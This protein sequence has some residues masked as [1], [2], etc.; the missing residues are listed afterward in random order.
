ML[1]DSST[2][3]ARRVF[4]YCLERYRGFF[5]VFHDRFLILEGDEDDLIFLYSSSVHKTE[6]AAIN[7]GAGYSKSIAGGTID[8]TTRIL[9]FCWPS[10]PFACQKLLSAVADVAVLDQLEGYCV[11]DLTGKRLGLLK[12]FWQ[13]TS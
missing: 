11:H 7:Y 8:Q 6:A 13:P 3:R 9:R 2:E 12:D 10:D 1:N 4:P 5:P